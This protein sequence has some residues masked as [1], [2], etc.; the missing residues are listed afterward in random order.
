MRYSQLPP[1]L[2]LL[3]LLVCGACGSAPAESSSSSATPARTGDLPLAWRGAYDDGLKLYEARLEIEHA[4]R[5]DPAPATLVLSSFPG[6]LSGGRDSSG[7][8]RGTFGFDAE[9]QLAHFVSPQLKLSWCLASPADGLATIPS[10]SGMCVL[11]A[12]KAGK[13]FVSSTGDWVKSRGK[14]GGGGFFDTPPN[15]EERAWGDHLA[16]SGRGGPSWPK[17]HTWLIDP[18]WERA[19][20]KPLRK[21]SGPEARATSHEFAKTSRGPFTDTTDPYPQYRVVYSI[22]RGL[23][24]RAY[25]RAHAAHALTVW[26]DN[27]GTR[28]AALSES[29]SSFYSLQA[30]ENFGRLAE[31]HLPT[32]YQSSW[33][34]TLNQRRNQIADPAL[35]LAIDDLIEAS[36]AGDLA[37][38]SLASWRIKFSDLVQHANP[39][40]IQ[41]CQAKVDQEADR[42]LPDY[43][44][45]SF[46]ALEFLGSGL[47]GLA[48]GWELYSDTTRELQGLESRPLF[49]EWLRELRIVR[50]AQLTDSWP[51]MQARISNGKKEALRSGLPNQWFGVAGDRNHPTFRSANDALKQRQQE[52]N[53]E[54]LAVAVGL[55][56]VLALVAHEFDSPPSGGSSAQSD[57]RQCGGDGLV[58]VTKTRDCLACV[59][60]YIPNSSWPCPNLSCAG[61]TDYYKEE[62]NCGECH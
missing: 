39:R 33:L 54:G 34:A 42:V 37:P 28:A 20:G 5:I 19:F 49:Q 32:S 59:N 61:G 18:A 21:M 8:H 10:E 62:V 23:K 50:D 4:P 40:V 51:A 38:I 56:A 25:L 30:Q 44:A 47:T 3:A 11:K 13:N 45:P 2:A 31:P 27:T 14:S 36:L 7:T 60:G 58:T 12:G 9:S 57:C 48:L 53:T 16:N 52:L 46:A 1:V 17:I 22:L 26:L 41:S 35:E 15:E 6:S 55:I 43:L 29:A 24:P